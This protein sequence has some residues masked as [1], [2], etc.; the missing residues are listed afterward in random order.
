[1][2]TLNIINANAER[3]ATEIVDIHAEDTNP[4]D[5]VGRSAVVQLDSGET[6]VGTVEAKRNKYTPHIPNLIIRFDNGT[7][8]STGGTLYLV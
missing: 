6:R 8:A 7:W 3:L 1:M 5:Y 4:A 2:N